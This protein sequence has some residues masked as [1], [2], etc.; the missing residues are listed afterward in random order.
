MVTIDKMEDIKYSK[1][2]YMK[3][4]CGIPFV[5]RAA[6]LFTESESDVKIVNSRSHSCDVVIGIRE[7]PVPKTERKKSMASSAPAI[8]NTSS[9]NVETFRG[10]LTKRK[11]KG[12]EEKSKILRSLAKFSLIKD[13][14]KENNNTKSILR[15]PVV[16]TYTKGVSGL[17]RRLNEPIHKS[18]P[19]ISM[20]DNDYDLYSRSNSLE[21]KRQSR[22][23]SLVPQRYY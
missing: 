2:E 23:F 3:R 14:K 17:P 20:L 18:N 9:D 6:S 13:T 1:E 10:R 11:S 4:A 7:D 8:P 22:S 16:S 15:P 19:H 21:P 5:D 12:A